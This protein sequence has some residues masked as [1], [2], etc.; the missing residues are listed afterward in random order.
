MR[1]MALECFEIFNKQCLT[2]LQDF[3]QIKKHNILL[4]TWKQRI[5]QKVDSATYGLKSF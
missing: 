4:D 2:Y 3:I 5:Y 1:T